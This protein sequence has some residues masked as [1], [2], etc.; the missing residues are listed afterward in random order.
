MKMRPVA[1][2]AFGLA[3]A[4][5]LPHGEAGAGPILASSGALQSWTAADLD[6]SGGRYWD[7]P[8]LDGARY[9]VGHF[10]SGTGAFSGN[11]GSPNATPGYWGTGDGG[12][13][14]DLWFRGGRPV[15]AEIRLEAGALRDKNE[16][17]WCETDAGGTSLGACT[18]LFGGSAGVG[19]SSAF[20]PSGYHA[21]Y[22]KPDA[23]RDTMFS[24]LSKF[25]SADLGRQHFAVFDAGNAYWLA[26]EDLVAPQG[27]GGIGDYNDFVARIA[28]VQAVPE[29]APL[30]LVGAGL[31]VLGLLARRRRSDR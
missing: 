22:F 5:C 3:I 29:P 27:E 9:N 2:A 30:A 10:L 17:G 20:A 28:F 7:Q 15:T 26:I 4:W 23:A 18:A 8:S 13:V 25:N 12:P 11:A 16:F 21:Y 14:G 19:A 1:A 24:T 6:E 31:I